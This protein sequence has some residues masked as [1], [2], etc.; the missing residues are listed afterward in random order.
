MAAAF[1][2]SHTG[3]LIYRQ[4][5]V[6]DKPPP[7][8]PEPQ[9]AQSP[10]RPLRWV[11]R[12]EVGEQAAAPAGWSGLGPVAGRQGAPPCIATIPMAATWWIFEAGK[13]S[14]RHGSPLTP[15]RTTPRLLVA[16]RD[17]HRVLVRAANGKWGGTSSR[18]PTHATIAADRDGR[19]SAAPMSW[20]G[21]R[22]VYWTSDPKTGSGDIWSVAVCGTGGWR[23][24]ADSDRPD[25]S[26]RAQPTGFPGREMDRVQLERNGQERDLHQAVP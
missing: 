11:G 23:P 20:S 10:D 1:A 17:T 15:H 21:D 24:Q 4:R 6:S 14:R 25:T 13:R 2:A 22:L 8:A 3:V 9:A 7:C 26:R 5:P 18:R 19:I 16:R 12:T